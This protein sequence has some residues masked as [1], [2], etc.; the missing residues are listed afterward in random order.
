MNPP[1]RLVLRRAL[2]VAA[3]L[4]VAPRLSS[5]ARAADACV[6][7]STE[8]LRTSLNYVSVSPDPAKP[9]S[10]CAFF[11]PDA[12]KPACGNCMIMT[13]LVDEK[14]HCDSWSPKA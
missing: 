13:G 8:A 1:R 7:H 5:P 9:C 10:V 6:D 4:V 11:T 12:G 2:Q 3:A 14:G